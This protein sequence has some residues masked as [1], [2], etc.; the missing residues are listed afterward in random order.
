MDRLHGRIQTLTR[1]AFWAITPAAQALLIHNLLGASGNNPFA[2]IFADVE[3]A[4][5]AV[6]GPK[7]NKVMVMPITGVLT[8]DDNWFGT[9]YNAITDAAEQAA[10]DPTIKRVVLAVD[11]PGGE[12]TGLPETAAVLAAL[13][14]VKP[15]S[16]IVEGQSAS[17]AFWLT[18][19]A[20][21]IT[22]A[23]SAELGSVGVRMMH[24]DISKALETDGIKVTELHAGEFKTEWSPFQPLSEAAQEDMQQRLNAIHGDFINAVA[25]GRSGR[26][27]A[28]IQAARFGEGRMFDS[29]AAL[30][31]GLAD[32]VQAP[33]DFYRA[34]TPVEEAQPVPNYGIRRAQIDQEKVRY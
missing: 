9:T 20:K 34:M 15:V 26:A 28:D 21:D 12:V 8:K 6:R 31:H 18:T 14:K 10:S 3:A 32:K 5:P 25:T 7:D 16:A 19:Q 2:T 33:R 30:G 4:K 11:S 27:T 1:S 17:A 24:V 23:P 13:A 29:K 22:I